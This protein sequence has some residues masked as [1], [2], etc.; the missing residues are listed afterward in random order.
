[1][2]VVHHGVETT[3][4][5]IR[6]KPIVVAPHR[7]I[8]Q[9]GTY[10]EICKMQSPLSVYHCSESDACIGKTRYSYTVFFLSELSKRRKLWFN[11]RFTIMPYRKI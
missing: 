4:G 2:C 7:Y 11:C 8:K 6:I 3:E 5:D 10:C 1:M 9:M